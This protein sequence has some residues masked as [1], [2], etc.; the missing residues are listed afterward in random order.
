MISR[1]KAHVIRHSLFQAG[2]RVAVAVSG[3]A[4]SVALLRIMLEVREEFGIVLS[5]AHFNHKIRGA[6]SAADEH[7]VRDLAQQHG[8][9]LHVSSGNTP[10]HAASARQSLETAGRELRYAFF[11]ELLASHKAGKV[12]TAHTI[13]DQA[14]TVLMR[15]FRGAGTRGL[16]GIYPEQATA[17][18][19]VIRPLLEFH[20]AELRDYLRD[21][22]Q[23]WR[24]DSTNSD[25]RHTRNRI[26]Q[27]LLPLLQ[28]NYNP[29]IV[30]T[31]AR[32]AEVA[33]A[34]EDYWS[35][36]CERLLPLV[37]LPGKPVRGGG[38]S[39]A[40]GAATS[41]GLRI[42]ALSK[43]PEALQRRLVRMAAGRLSIALDLDHVTRI[44]DLLA[45]RSKSCELSGGWKVTTGLRE[46]RFEPVPAHK[47]AKSVRPAR[48]EIE[49][50][51]Y[52]YPLPVPGSVRVPEINS[53]VHTRLLPFATETKGYNHS[54]SATRQTLGAN[55]LDIGDFDLKLRSWHP[56]DRFWP[57]HTS[58]EKKVKELLQLLK[59]KRPMRKLWPVV[60]AGERV[61]WVRGTRPRQ[62]CVERDG[63]KQNLIIEAE[64][65]QVPG[66]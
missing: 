60:A 18:P 25:V 38:R 59:V 27:E 2:D 28:Q 14:E 56:G 13:D 33:R 17:A 9:E 20:R 52:E 45:G 65:I 29:G 63:V 41:W 47:P 48:Q 66:A 24:E 37:F 31:L 3:G 6:D 8:L 57:P 42:D 23:P 64:E 46:L 5:V 62:I 26:R 19:A 10:A 49:C 40:T 12:A 30:E 16:A 22:N 61:I 54:P 53:L 21:R 15:L 36:E 32:T 58:S 44:L 1:F 11:K 35:K 50:R 51:G 7:F 4:D 55:A 43:Q 39:V 34:E